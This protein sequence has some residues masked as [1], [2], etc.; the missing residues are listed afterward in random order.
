MLDVGE[1]YSAMMHTHSK[2]LFQN[3]YMSTKTRI[4]YINRH[5][6]SEAMLDVGACE[7]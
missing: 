2:N 5:V 7:K 6:E 1:T 3:Y 4:E